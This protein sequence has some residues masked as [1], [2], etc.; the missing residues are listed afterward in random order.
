MKLGFLFW[1]EGVAEYKVAAAVEVARKSR[2]DS[3]KEV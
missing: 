1:A 3:I 2:R